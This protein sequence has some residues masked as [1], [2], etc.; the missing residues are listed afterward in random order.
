MV[1]PSTTEP[2]ATFS[3]PVYRRLRVF[4]LNPGVA[5]RLEQVLGVVTTVSVPWEDLK[6]GPVGNYLEVIDYDPPSRCF[7]PRSTSTT[8]CS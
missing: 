6:P 7:Y 8:R 4:A 3:Y 1:K 5:V 2:D